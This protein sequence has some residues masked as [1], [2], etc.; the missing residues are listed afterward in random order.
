MPVPEDI[1]YLSTRRHFLSRTSLGLG[2]AALASLLN[3]LGLLAGSAGSAAASTGGILDRPHFVPRARRI[4]YL[5]QSGGPSQLELFDYKP[6]LRERN[7]EELPPSVR[8][9]QR[10]TGMTANQKS[11]PMAGSQFDFAR[12]GKSGLWVSELLPYTARI[13]DE[14]CVIKSMHTEAINH[15]PAITFFQTGS[16]QAGRPSMG[17]WLS[18]GLGSMNENLPAF[19]VLLS[20]AREGGQPLYSRLWGPG[21]LP[22]LHQGVQFRSGKDPVLYLNDPPG[23]GTTSRRRMLDAL[24]EL[25]H[26]QHRQVMDPEIDTRIAQY[27]MAYRMQTSVP[28]VMDL[29]DEPDSTFE[30]YGEEARRPGTF[31]ANCLLARRLA[32]RDVRFIQLYHQGWDQHGNLP[33]DIQIMTRSVDQASAALVIDLKQRGLL[34]DTLVVWGGEFGR[35]NYSQGKLTAT[36]YGRDHHPRCFTVWMAGGGVKRGFVYGETDE[37][38][39]NIV[40]DPVHV[41]DFQ[42]TLLYLLGIDHER[43][44][45][46]H[47]GRR[48]RLT[49]VHGHVVK[50]ILA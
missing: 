21:F 29:S 14:L 12:H 50:P 36:N 33:E 11:F 42:A 41:H 22:S 3:P 39:Y 45:F 9:G 25:H 30:L 28:D 4:I 8:G 6:L 10:L 40:R 32:E 27:E 18:Y 17:S 49:D 20:R 7:G 23:L 43:L 5:F 44:T 15:D 16:Q 46:K 19:I 34:D 37:F 31:A 38:G 13:A 47:Q 26:H 35:T 1:R 24:R 48:Y 2:A